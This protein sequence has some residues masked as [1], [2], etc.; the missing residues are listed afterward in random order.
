MCLTCGTTEKD[1]R[2]GSPLSAWM[3]RATEEDWPKRSSYRQLQEARKKD[4]DG[5]I[6]PVKAV[7][8]PAQLALPGSPQ[9]KQLCHLH[10]QLSLGQSCHRQKNLASMHAGD[11]SV[12][13]NSLQPCRLWPARILCQKVG[14]SKQEYWSVLANTDCHTL[15]EHYISCCPSCQLPWIPGAARTP[16]TQAAALLPPLALTGANASP[17]GQT[18]EQTPVDNPYPEVEIKP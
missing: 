14:F 16:E 11:A 7:Y 6:T 1:P 2:Q 13:S 15:L 17:P 12:V 8:V 4:S 5:A 18:Q 3:G 10:A 9:A